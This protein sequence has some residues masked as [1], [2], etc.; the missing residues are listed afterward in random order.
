LPYSVKEDFVYHFPNATLLPI[1][2]NNNTVTYFLNIEP[3]SSQYTF[4]QLQRYLLLSDKHTHILINT[5]APM[6]QKLDTLKE[7]TTLKI[8][9]QEQFLLYKYY[10][11]KKTS[12][13]RL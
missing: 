4:E 6:I 8:T 3:K 5:N 11:H 10:L 13:S 2:Q 1:H 7:V 9:K 12:Q